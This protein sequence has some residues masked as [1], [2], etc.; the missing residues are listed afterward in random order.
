MRF[1]VVLLSLALLIG[2]CKKGETSASYDKMDHVVQSNIEMEQK[3]AVL[4]DEM[5]RSG[6][7]S[8]AGGGGESSSAASPSIAP[9][10]PATQAVG[11][12]AQMLIKT[13]NLPFQVKKFSV[14]KR[15]ITTIIPKFSGYVSSENESNYSDNHQCIMSI[16]VPSAKF[17][18]LVEAVSQSALNF[19][20]RQISV[21]DVGEEFA[22]VSARM[23]AKKEVEVRYIAI[24][25]R[26]NKISEILE[27]EQKIGEV[28]AE[29]ESMQGRLNYLKSQVSYSTLNITFYE[30]TPVAVTQRT[31]FFSQIGYSIQTGWVGML[32]FMI[33]IAGIWPFVLF[34]TVLVIIIRRKVKTSRSPKK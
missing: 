15:E 25:T 4:S 23:K 27:I 28:R 29:I 9:V 26:A 21:Q 17:D 13:G 24:L 12:Q 20:T 1:N 16:R 32:N 6:G 5:V 22:D 34:V 3:S 8:M 11:I 10:A 30:R 31:N 7:S 14:A 33:H 19:D 2:S 18:G